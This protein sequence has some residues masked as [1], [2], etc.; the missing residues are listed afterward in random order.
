MFGMLFIINFGVTVAGKPFYDAIA[1]NKELVGDVNLDEP[2]DKTIKE[3]F[4]ILNLKGIMYYGIGTA[5][6]G[7]I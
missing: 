7:I 2:V 1:D 4:E 6:A 3:G 5:C